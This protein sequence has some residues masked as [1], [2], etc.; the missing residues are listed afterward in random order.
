MTDVVTGP[1]IGATTG[2]GVTRPAGAPGRVAAV[3]RQ[4]RT[5]LALAAAF[6]LTAPLTA[7]LPHRTGS[8]L[9]LH[10]FLVGALLLAISGATQLFAV[11][12][13]AAPAPPGPVAAAQ[14]WSLAAGAAGLAAGREARAPDW[15]VA[16][17]GSV[18]ALALVL[19]AVLLVRIVGTGVQRRFDVS[20][21]WYLT[22]LA[23]GLVGVGLGVAMVAGWHLPW[24]PGR[25]RSA[26]LTLNLLGLVGLTVA[27]TLPFF[28]A[29]EARTKMSARAGAIRQAGLL[30]VLAAAL[31]LAG[32]GLLV[33][34]RGLSAAGLAG[35]ATGVLAVATLLP[36]LGRRQLAWAG[37]RLVHLGAGLSWWAGAT[38]AAA[39]EVLDGRPP[40]DGRVLAV[41]VVGGYAQV[42]AGALAYLGPV[43]RGGGHERLTAGFA[44]TRS[45]GGLVAAN[46][47]AAA[48]AL[49]ATRLAAVL[50]ALWVADA[51]LRAARL[52]AP[53]RRRTG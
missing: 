50:V 19:L 49:G 46:A 47:A 33:G 8:W 7:V 16:T 21:A 17:A 51:A 38:V 22:A 41:L 30:A 42:L 34:A 18:V 40:F 24:A 25:V 11:T 15:V 48:V 53:G 35:Y 27:G 45:W 4:T 14:R 28:V 44:T 31:A 20:L 39:G 36:R 12:W 5:T 10:L 43:L 37:P 1:R 29:T 2:P 52:A 3:H 26:H 9:P 13:S 23:A 6:A 32:A